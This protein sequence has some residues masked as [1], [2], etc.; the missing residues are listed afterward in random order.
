MVDRDHR[1]RG[2]GALGGAA[3]G[4]VASREGGDGEGGEVRRGSGEVAS[5][6][7]G[8]GG[9]DDQ[10][11]TETRFRALPAA[12]SLAARGAVEKAMTRAALKAD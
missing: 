10:R 7:R 11:C 12:M 6:K 1:R 4:H 2:A 8:G 9:G 3:T 5:H